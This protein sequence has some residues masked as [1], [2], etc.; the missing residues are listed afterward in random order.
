MTAVR[1]RWLPV[2]SFVPAVVEGARS[3]SRSRS[4]IRLAVRST[5]PGSSPPL[6][7]VRDLVAQ[8]RH[9]V[10]A[11]ARL[12]GPGEELVPVARHL[13]R[14]HVARELAADALLPERAEAASRHL[15]ARE[16]CLRRDQLFDLGDAR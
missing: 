14:A 9:H 1:S 10:D 16:H 11:V 4:T 2:V 5:S 7:D 3:T 6:R 12:E 8:H 15:L 13:K